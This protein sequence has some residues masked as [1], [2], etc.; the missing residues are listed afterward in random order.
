M[1]EL[2]QQQPGARVAFVLITKGVGRD[3]PAG[4]EARLGA[5]YTRD[6]IRGTLQFMGCKPRHA[7]KAA[8]LLFAKLER[9]ASEGSKFSSGSRQ[10]WS[11]APHGEG[12]VYVA[13]PRSEFYEIVCGTLTEYNYKYA[14]SSDEIK[15]ACRC[16]ERVCW[17]GGRVVTLAARWWRRGGEGGR[18]GGPE[19]APLAPAMDA[20]TRPLHGRVG[21]APGGRGEGG[22]AAFPFLLRVAER[23]CRAYAVQRPPSQHPL[24]AP[25]P[26]CSPS[27]AHHAPLSRPGALLLYA[28][29]RRRCHRELHCCSLKERR[30]HIVILLCG[31][32]GSGKSTLASI[33]VGWGVGASG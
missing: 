1:A 18:A 19:G 6:A 31:T 2:V 24:S 11:V 32:S 8:L 13:M 15:V 10:L 22:G 17:W 23:Q 33:L 5:R 14:P 21:A 28:P 26:P 7:Y 12:Q 9:F 30:R 27:A 29:H 25:P 4:P 20:S 3:F 16:G